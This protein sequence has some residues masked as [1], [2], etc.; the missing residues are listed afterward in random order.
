M[1]KIKMILINKNEKYN[2]L[3]ENFP[4]NNIWLYIIVY[5]ILDNT[6]KKFEDIPRQW[7]LL[8][9]KHT[10]THPKN[11]QSFG[12]LWDNITQSIICAIGV[13]EGKE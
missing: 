11:E 3:H 13:Q 7:N 1:E 10:Y 8:P 9:M 6:H 5:I 2:I 4:G 12:D